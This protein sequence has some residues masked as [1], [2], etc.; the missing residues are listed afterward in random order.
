MVRCE[1]IVILRSTCDYRGVTT[2]HCVCECGRQFTANMEDIINGK[3]KD[4]G[5]HRRKSDKAVVSSG[6]PRGH[7]MC[8]GECHSIDEWAKIAQV[9]AYIIK[10]RLYK[11]HWSPETA[12][13]TKPKYYN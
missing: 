7:I 4:C 1:N 5:Y 9:P 2:A 13:F 3:V 11:L 6:L 8:R 10:H 12:V